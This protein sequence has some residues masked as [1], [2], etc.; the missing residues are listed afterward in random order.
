MKF[1]KVDLRKLAF[2][3]EIKGFEL[4]ENKPTCIGS[5]G[6]DYRQVFKYNGKF[7]VTLYYY[8]PPRL[9]DEWPYLNEGNMIECKEV[10]PKEIKATVYITDEN[11]SDKKKHNWKVGDMVNIPNVGG[12]C[13]IS[14][15]T[16]THIY[17][18]MITDIHTKGGYGQ[19]VLFDEIT[20]ADSK[21]LN[22]TLEGK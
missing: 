4:V 19:T 11:K 2:D 12:I 16:E 8:S 15:I 6:I 5:E 21:K 1:Q 13:C 22:K 9:S 20:Y 3:N 10:W 14:E 7:Y 18:D 17:F